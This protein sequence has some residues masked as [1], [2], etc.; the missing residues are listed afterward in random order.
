M[1]D[2]H[3]ELLEATLVEQHVEPFAR[4]QL[5]LGMLRGDPLLAATDTRGLAAAFEFLH[6]RR[7][8]L[9]S[10]DPIPEGGAKSKRCR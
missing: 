8:G 7:H 1:L 10:T 9:S 6:R 4:G 3:V 5:A 2:E